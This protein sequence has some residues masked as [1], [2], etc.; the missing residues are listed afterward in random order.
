[1][2]I[3]LKME[4]F[5]LPC[6]KASKECRWNA[7]SADPD[8][9]SKEQSALGLHCKLKP[10]CPNTRIYKVYVVDCTVLIK[11]SVVSLIFVYVYRI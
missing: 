6:I 7:N 11:T 1:M 3:V 4:H 9:T 8:Q 10:I 2:I 5:F